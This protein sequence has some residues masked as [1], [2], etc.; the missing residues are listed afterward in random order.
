VYLKFNTANGANYSIAEKT[1]QGH[2][3]ASE[4]ILL[5]YLTYLLW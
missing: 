3:P 2:W 4:D 5:S 1:E